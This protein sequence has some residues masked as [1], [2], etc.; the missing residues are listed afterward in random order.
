MMMCRYDRKNNPALVHKARST[1]CIS[2]QVGCKMGCTFCATGTM[3][4]TYFFLFFST[5][6]PTSVFL[7]FL[8]A[9]ILMLDDRSHLTAG[10]I[11][12]QLVHASR[13]EPIK[14]VVFMGMV[15]IF[16]FSIFRICTV[17]PFYPQGEP[18]DNYE[19]VVTA[20]KTMIDQR[21]YSAGA[22]T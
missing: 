1:V 10:E 11:V 13:V 21:R 12:E 17:N 22:P 4:F 2:S 7:C 5:P 19:N 14:N 18:L 9:L 8:F 20:I 6:S 16:T 3:G 15:V